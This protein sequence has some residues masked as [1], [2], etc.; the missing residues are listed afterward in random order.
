MQVFINGQAR[1]FDKP[2]DIDMVIR[3]LGIEAQ[4]CAV[5]LNEAVVKRE[6]W[7]YT[8]LKENDRLECLQF[9]GG[10]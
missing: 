8:T 5:A 9:M 2:L 6:K 10:G 1:E 3:E 4:V 7:S